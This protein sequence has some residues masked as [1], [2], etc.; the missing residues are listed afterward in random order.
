MIIQVITYNYIEMKTNFEISY[1][2]NHPCSV[3]N[4]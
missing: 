3:Y 1:L 2:D 4:S